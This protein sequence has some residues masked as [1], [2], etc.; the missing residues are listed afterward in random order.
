[1]GADIYLCSVYEPNIAKWQKTFDA[2][3]KARDAKYPP[4]SDYVAVRASPE[5]KAV[6]E[7]YNQMYA[8]GYF[9]DSYNSTSLFW[10][11]GISWRGLEAID[12]EGLMSP[13]KCRALLSTL[14]AR[15]VTEQRI[16]DWLKKYC[17]SDEAKWTE[18]FTKKHAKLCALLRQAI[19]LNEPLYCSV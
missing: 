2:A 14:E 9:R 19:E 1:M 16:G 8:V 18:Y 12:E 11:L 5:Q 4:G 7:A 17:Q 13:D 3:A 10:L 6:D 15:P